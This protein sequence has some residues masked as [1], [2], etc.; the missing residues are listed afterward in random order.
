LYNY[1]RISALFLIVFSIVLQLFLRL[2]VLMSTKTK[3]EASKA[4]TRKPRRANRFSKMER[5]NQSERKNRGVLYMGHL[6]EGFNE[7]EVR[8]FFS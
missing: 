4:I 5:M 6:P 1:P 8:E 7:Q 3:S 2:I